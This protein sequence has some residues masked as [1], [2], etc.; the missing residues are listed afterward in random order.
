[1]GRAGREPNSF[2]V[3]I[4]VLIRLSLFGGADLFGSGHERLL[5]GI[6]IQHAV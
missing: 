4:D 2:Q 6:V 5:F 3:C 1:M